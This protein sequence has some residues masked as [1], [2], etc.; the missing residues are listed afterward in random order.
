MDRLEEMLQ[1]EGRAAL[2]R[3]CF[4]AI[5]VL[6]RLDIEGFAGLFEH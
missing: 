1:R 6:A 2:A 5:P 3:E 4:Q